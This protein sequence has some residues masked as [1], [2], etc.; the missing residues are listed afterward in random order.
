MEDT[1]KKILDA[2]RVSV[3]DIMTTMAMSDVVYVGMETA[4]NFRLGGQGCVG[5]VRLSG[6]HEGMIAAVCKRDLL[7]A[8]VSSIIG[9]PPK[10]LQQEDLL[11]G[12]AE[13][14]NMIGGGMKSMAKV[15]GVVLSSPMAL[16]GNDYVIEWKTG[17]QTNILTFQMEQG[18]LRVHTSL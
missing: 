16:L 9:L 10:E 14:A 8:V 17:R 1:R 15:P 13:L 11:D 2:L 4:D 18:I 3:V 12:A 7:A 6:A 5:M